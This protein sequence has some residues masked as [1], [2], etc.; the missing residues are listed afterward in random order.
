MLREEYS[1]KTTRTPA[2]FEVDAGKRQL[3]GGLG[4]RCYDI[5]VFDSAA[6]VR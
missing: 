3:M 6:E 2:K 1:L 4:F 5:M